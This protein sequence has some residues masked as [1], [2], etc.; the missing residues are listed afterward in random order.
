MSSNKQHCRKTQESIRKSIF[1]HGKLYWQRF[2]ICHQNHVIPIWDGNSDPVKNTWH[3]K[4]FKCQKSKH[5]QQSLYN[6]RISDSP[7]TLFLR[8]LLAQLYM[9][10][11][12][13]YSNYTG[14]Y[15]I[16]ITIYIECYFIIWEAKK[17]IYKKRSRTHLGVKHLMTNLE[18][19]IICISKHPQ[20]TLPLLWSSF[21]Q[22][23]GS[24]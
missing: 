1:S 6:C 2:L 7:F 4:V 18:L 5:T 17:Q 21:Y 12:P 15:G 22:L 9:T 8:K 20:V 19:N 16:M 13:A 23:L 24:G 3:G 14:K 10:Y 11:R